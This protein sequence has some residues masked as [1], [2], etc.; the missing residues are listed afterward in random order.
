MF[1]ILANVAAVDSVAGS[2]GHF[3]GIAAGVAGVTVVAEVVVDDVIVVVVVVVDTVAVDVVGILI[4]IW[5][6]GAIAVDVA[7]G[8]GSCAG[9]RIDRI[10]NLGWPASPSMNCCFKCSQ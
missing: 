10:D 5:I 7:A 3:I 8:K 2:V 9:F 4:D 1:F 6:V